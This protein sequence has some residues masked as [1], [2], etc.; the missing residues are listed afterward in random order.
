MKITDKAYIELINEDI[1]WVEKQE[2]SLEKLH[3]IQILNVV[4]GNLK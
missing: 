2:H 1:E 3:I 4:I